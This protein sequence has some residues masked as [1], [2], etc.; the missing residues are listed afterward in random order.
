MRDPSLGSLGRADGHPNDRKITGKSHDNHRK[1]TRKSQ[2]QHTE[3]TGK[4][5]R[6]RRFSTQESQ[7]PPK[8]SRPL[9]EIS[10][11]RSQPNHSHNHKNNYI[12][13]SR[14]CMPRAVIRLALENVCRP[15]SGPSNNGG[16][17]TGNVYITWIFRPSPIPS[18]EAPTKLYKRLILNSLL[19]S[20]LF[21]VLFSLVLV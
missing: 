14:V 20:L 8:R 15:E 12:S 21:R 5:H 13:L 3:I 9:T 7:G 11:K 18:I 4:S 16:I 17:L 2:E 1:I 6:N 10:H 19:S